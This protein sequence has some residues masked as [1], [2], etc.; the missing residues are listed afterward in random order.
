[1]PAREAAAYAEAA[2]RDGRPRAGYA[3]LERRLGWDPL[4]PPETVNRELAGAL[5]DDAR[6]VP[7][8]LVLG[9]AEHRGEI[10]A[11]V[12]QRARALQRFFAD[13]VLGE[14]R[15]LRA[16]SGLTES[17]L[18][19]ILASEGTSLRELRTRWRDQSPHSIRFVYGPDLGREPSGRWVVLEDNVGCVSACADSFLALDAYARACGLPQ[20]SR[21]PDLSVAVESWLEGLGLAV[22]D[23]G[24]VA[25]L[26]DAHAAR[27][28]NGVRFDEDLRRQALLRRLG[29]RVVDN[30]DLERIAAESGCGL[31]ALR[32]IVNI[33]VPSAR[34]WP[35]LLDAFFGRA[36]VPLLNAPGTSVL[37]SK[38]LLPFVGHMVSFYLQE[39]AILDSPPTIV[40]RDG[41]LPDDPAGWVVKAAAGCGGE[42]VLELRSRTATQ[43][44]ALERSL[45][46][47]WPER[48]AVAQR[49]VELSRLSPGGGAG[50]LVELRALG[51]VVGWQEVF[52]GEQC[53][54]RLTPVDGQHGELHVAPVLSASQ[55]GDDGAGVRA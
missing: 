28:T 46:D 25:L 20:G 54:A 3:E 53:L 13:V 23:R 19:G 18:D 34:T 24:V 50:Y 12:A 52:A 4:R 27:W 29:V 21:R 47:S 14:G 16:G 35:M 38:A 31:G 49:R 30:A 7:V 40:L 2:D 8:P 55:A 43:L 39:D 15:F 51:Y 45:A 42:E 11:G 6:I 36:R 1:V 37:G 48:A 44:R 26:T 10:R 33:G 22:T 32:A 17:L 41:R 5:G 9:V